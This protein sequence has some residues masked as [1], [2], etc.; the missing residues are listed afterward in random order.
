MESP[1]TPS[2]FRSLRARIQP[3]STSLRRAGKIGSYWLAPAVATALA[4]QLSSRTAVG[5][6]PLSVPYTQT[7][8][9]VASLAAAVKMS[10]VNVYV[11]QVGTGLVLGRD[12]FQRDK[13]RGQGSGFVVDNAGHVVTNAHVVHGA[14]R[15]R[16]RFADD[17]EVEAEVRGE[18][19]KLD[20]A[21]LELK[22]AK[23]LTPVTFGSSDALRV[24]E[25]AIA[26]GNP[27]GLGHTVTMGIVSAKSRSI[28]AGPYDDFIQT[29][30]SI[31]P[32][33]SGG[34]LF[35]QR[36]EVI[37][38]NTA[39]NAQAQGIGF[40]IPIDALKAVL[41]QLI[42]KGL[43][44]RGRLGVV[45]ETRED[46]SPAAKAH[47][48]LIADVEP[49]SPGALAGLRAGDRI[50]SVEG[51]AIERSRDLPKRIAKFLPG[52]TVHLGVERNGK[53][54]ALAVVL[55]GTRGDARR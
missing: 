5:G 6:P 7:A 16:V 13:K 8:P 51:V 22:D 34:P 50:R 10:V 42:E 18:D 55:G 19:P 20:L 48:A 53:E 24:G 1:G 2:P 36:A 38:I 4:L 29:D 49:G 15:V 12:G 54:Q 28:G 43:V 32:G 14:S 26:I 33:N 25:Y 27:F 37:G 45:I 46:D 30:A 17:R 11:E 41:P 31:N 9:D 52:E 3:W 40:A 39:I 35:N 23:G 44:E 21:V 47:G